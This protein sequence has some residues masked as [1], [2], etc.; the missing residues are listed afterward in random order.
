MRTHLIT[1]SSSGAL[2]SLLATAAASSSGLLSI[3]D[4]LPTGWFYQGCWSPQLEA[5]AAAR[6]S[7]SGRGQ[8]T[9]EACAGFCSGQG[10]SAAGVARGEHCSCW[11][12]DDFAAGRLPPGAL[13]QLPEAECDQPCAGGGD[14]VG[15]TQM[16]GGAASDQEGHGHVALFVHLDG[17]ARQNNNNH[18]RSDDGGGNGTDEVEVEGCPRCPRCNPCPRPPYPT[19]P[20]PTA[21][22]TSWISRTSTTTTSSSQVCIDR[23]SPLWA[24]YRC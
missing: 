12:W 3:S 1:A 24:G 8:M 21:F 11:D 5:A 17:L 14:G 7:Y 22:P 4:R 23:R 6:A 16:C 15:G 2:L 9:Q 13:V 18:A 10:H 20:P 19:G